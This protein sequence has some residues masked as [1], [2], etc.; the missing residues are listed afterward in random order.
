MST[1]DN[2]QVEPV[3]TSPQ[4]TILRYG[5]IGGLVLIVY[6]L[7]NFVLGLSKPSA[8]TFVGFLNIFVVIAIY[9]FMMIYAVRDHRD[10]NQGGYITFGKAFTVAFLTSLLAALINTVFTILY[11]NVID[12]GYVGDIMKASEEFY[13][14]SGMPEQQIEMSLSWAKSMMEPKGQM[15]LFLIGTIFGAIISLIVASSMKKNPPEFQ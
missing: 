12:P 5:G 11:M 14:S 10:N 13:E 2:P 7:L 15:I 9:V 3:N 6:S 1:L 8:G 4:Q